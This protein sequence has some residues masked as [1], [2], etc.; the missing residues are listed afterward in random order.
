MRL[1]ATRML[2]RF[3]LTTLTCASMLFGDS[4]C[5]CPS[6]AKGGPGGGVHCAGKQMS[7]CDASSGE[8]NCECRPLQG[9]SREE[10]LSQIYSFG[11]DK[12]VSA[13]DLTLPHYRDLTS[14]FLRSNNNGTFTLMKRSAD[15][16]ISKQLTIGLPE[17]V[18]SVLMKSE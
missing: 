18:V 7:K 5:R 10:Y 9:H 17:E 16:T 15:G 3:L 14:S 11:L 12:E 1:P 4:Q 6:K 13:S 2:S 8:C